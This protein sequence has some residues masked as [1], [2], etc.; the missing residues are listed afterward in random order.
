MS[1]TQGN[2]NSGV[3]AL[4]GFAFQRNSAIYLILDTPNLLE[5]GDFFISIEHHDDLIFG[6]TGDDGKITSVEAYQVKKNSTG[7]WS[8]NKELGNIV[9]K[10]TRVASDLRKDT[11]PKSDTYSHRLVFLSNRNITLKCGKTK[12]PK[13]VEIVRDSN[14]HS[15]YSELHQDIKKNIESKIIS[16]PHFESQNKKEID[17]LEFMYLDLPSTDKK[18]RETLQGMLNSVYGDKISDHAAALAVLIT[19][20]RDSETIYNQGNTCK[21]MDEEK[22]VHSK[23]INQA[24]DVITTKAKAYKLWRDHAQSL[25][26]KL[27]IPLSK[28]ESYKE[29]LNNCFDYF[30]D[31]E[32]AEYQKIFNFVDE[33][34]DV[35]EIFTDYSE[36]FLELRNRYLNANQSQLNSHAISFAIIAAYVETRNR[37]DEN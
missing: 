12:K 26:K 36:C 17:T 33:N 29:Q 31:L 35:D 28:S 20:F 27:N 3:E 15:R 37:K 5:E 2:V 24:L 16:S 32:Q 11:Y 6:H 9:A 13:Y 7:T 1:T 25:T 23:S 10:M 22:R 21:L 14:L 18:Q 8:V 4:T 19:L 34:R 30:K